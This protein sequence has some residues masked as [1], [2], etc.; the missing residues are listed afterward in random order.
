ME[1]EKYTNRM[2]GKVRHT[3]PNVAH[4][5]TTNTDRYLFLRVFEGLVEGVCFLVSLGQL[6][7]Q[8]VR[9][10]LPLSDFDLEMSFFFRG[11]IQQFASVGQFGFVQ[12]LKEKKDFV[13]PQ[14]YRV[15]SR[16]IFE[17]FKN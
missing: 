14:L 17:D 9:L 3:I 10:R 15:L 16:V 5:H 11:L 8:V 7:S 1:E 2:H 12:A 4:F 13:N 6:S